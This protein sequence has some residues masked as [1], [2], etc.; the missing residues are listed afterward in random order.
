V[1]VFGNENKELTVRDDPLFFA[2]LI[3]SLSLEFE[4]KAR[5]L[6]TL[7]QLPGSIFGK[8]PPWMSK[9]FEN[10]NNSAS[11][12]IEIKDPTTF[13]LASRAASNTTASA[14]DEKAP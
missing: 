9:F 7:L 6:L 13:T 10:V 3:F 2:T 14:A 5:C 11:T 4:N 12:A 1:S 8:E